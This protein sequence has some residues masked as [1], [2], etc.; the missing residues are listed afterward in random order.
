MNFKENKFLRQLQTFI[1]KSTKAAS[2]LIFVI[3][4][5]ISVQVFSRFALNTFVLGIIPLVQQSFAIFLLIGGAYIASRGDHIRVTVLFDLF[6]PRM[7]QFSKV[8]SFICMLIFLGIMIWQTSW[9]G[10][11]SLAHKETMNGIYKFMPMYPLKLFIP[12]MAIF[13]LIVGVISFF[14]TWH[15]DN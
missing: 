8:V 15:N 11:N 1:D 2:L 3:V 14:K 12:V 6:G 9:M 5:A 10:L 4:F 13:I 7:K